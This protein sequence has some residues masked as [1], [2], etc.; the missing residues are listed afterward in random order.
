MLKVKIQALIQYI[1]IFLLFQYIGGRFVSY[2]GIYFYIGVLVITLGFII[3]RKKTFTLCKEYFVWVLIILYSMFMTFSITLGDLSFWTILS[4]MSRFLIVYVAI[5]YDKEMF[6]E[7]LIKLAGFLSIISWITFYIVNVLNLSIVQPLLPYLAQVKG[8]AGDTITY[9]LFVFV[10]N[11]MDKTRNSGIF[12]E[13][14]ELQIMVIMALYFM[15]FHS[16]NMDK[17]EKLRYF[18]IF[19]ITMLTNQSTTGI[20]NLIALFLVCLFQPNW[21]IMSSL[22]NLIFAIVGGVLVYVTFFASEKSLVYRSFINKISVNGNVD[23]NQGTASAR[24]LSFDLLE[25]VIQTEP[26]SLIFG[27]GYGGL[28]KYSEYALVCSGL[29]SGLIMF[30]SITNLLIYGKIIAL[31]KQLSNNLLEFIFVVFVIINNGIGQPDILSIF[32][33]IIAGYTI[34]IIKNHNLKHYQNKFIAE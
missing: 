15:I 34:L 11:V 29:I 20:F 16:D 28:E 13:P 30:G 25:K 26:H 21:K 6:T 24:M 14:G 19:L 12:G 10:F 22:K 23:F 32:P 31:I 2:F 7:R 17:K 33:V 4:I 3:L 9:G 8:P 27:M 1:L 5:T 18:L